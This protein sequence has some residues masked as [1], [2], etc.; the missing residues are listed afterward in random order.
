MFD[1]LR[2]LLPLRHHPSICTLTGAAE[3]AMTKTAATGV[4]YNC[5]GDATQGSRK[6]RSP[7][8]F[9]A[10][11]RTYPIGNPGI[12]R[13]RGAD[14]CYWAVWIYRTCMSVLNP[15]WPD[16]HAL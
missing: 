3:H 13:A 5:Q 10:G 14:S 15:A 8:H 16:A 6:S 9:R 1:V 11:A 12:V 7:Y 2:A 4:M